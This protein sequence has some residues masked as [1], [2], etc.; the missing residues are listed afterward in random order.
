VVIAQLLALSALFTALLVALG[1]PAGFLVGPMF[2]GILVALRGHALALPKRGMAVCQALIGLM[3]SRSLTR[4][5][6]SLWWDHAWLFAAGTFVVIGLSALLGWSL[7]RT[8]VMPASAAL[9]GAAPG[10]ASAMVLLAEGHGGDGR[11]VALMQYVRVVVVSATAALGTRILGASPKPADPWTTVSLGGLALV[12]FLVA[13]CVI[14][15]TLVRFPALPLVLGMVLGAP[16]TV[17]LP[18][19][20]LIAAWVFIGW[21]VGLRFTAE[22]VRHA[23]RA[24]PWV[25]LANVLLVAACL[26]LAW[27]LAR[28]SGLDAVTLMLAM[29]PGGADTAAAIASSIGLE[30]TF[31]MALQMLRFA[32]VVVGSQW[33][34]RRQARSSR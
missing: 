28:V 18:P 9:W 31:V 11:L 8:R 22:L 16:F 23:L 34:A 24:L 29:S 2:A 1:V 4:E 13:V 14:A 3:I 21:S 19:V 5:T 15:G 6:L 7:A 32:V 12:A 26:G 33:V 25:V 27:V 20:V 30:V 17:E 10:A